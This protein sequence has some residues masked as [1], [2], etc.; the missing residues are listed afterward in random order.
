[1][2]DSNFILKNKTTGD[3]ICDYDLRENF[4]QICF[5]DRTVCLKFDILY[6]F[7]R[8]EDMEEEK[9]RQALEKARDTRAPLTLNVTP[10]NPPNQ[11]R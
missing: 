4:P 3:I 5:L 7:E 6:E 1:M 11:R 2:T 10:I 9:L 8:E